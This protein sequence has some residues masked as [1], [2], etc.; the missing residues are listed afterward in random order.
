[1]MFV[2]RTKGR[3]QYTFNEQLVSCYKYLHCREKQKY[4]ITFFCEKNKGIILHDVL[5]NSPE[6][7]FLLCYDEIEIAMNK[8]SN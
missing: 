7:D 6:N 1:M 8:L 4:H 3:V 2:R 5:P